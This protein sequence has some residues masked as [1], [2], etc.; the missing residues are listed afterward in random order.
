MASSADKQQEDRR[1]KDEAVRATI[2]QKL[3]E[4]GEKERLKEMLRSKLVECGWRD[5]LREHCK[6]VIRKKGLDRITVDE[7][8]AEITPHGR[9]TVPDKI[10]AD[11]LQR[12]RQFLQST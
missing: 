9:D 4:T 8:V 12:I 3:I 11:L 7:L 10:K 1:R 6:D 2:M 5:D